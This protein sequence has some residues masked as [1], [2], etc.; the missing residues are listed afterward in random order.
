MLAELEHAGVRVVPGPLKV[1]ISVSGR[2]LHLSQAH[3]EALF[4]RGFELTVFHPISQPGQYAS[5]QFVTLT[6]PKGSIPNLRVLGPVRS[7]TQVELAMSEARRI[8]LNLPVRSSGDIEGSTGAILTGPSGSVT[9]TEGVIVADRHIHMTPEQALTWG[10]ADAQ[11]VKVHI[12]TPKGAVLYNVSVRVR[13]DFTLDLHLDTD[14][15]NAL[16]IPRDCYG[17]VIP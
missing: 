12:D 15:A 11:L 2:H 13:A 4:G 3:L 10:F 9:L 1:P 8:G 7:Q 5:N 16:L 17:I 6:G 14:D